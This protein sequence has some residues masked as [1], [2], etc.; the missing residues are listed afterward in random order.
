MIL[1]LNNTTTPTQPQHNLNLTQLS[2]VWHDYDFAH[3][4]KFCM[5][6]YLQKLR[7]TQQN[8]NPS[9]FWGGG[10]YPSG[11]TLPFFC[12]QNFVPVESPTMLPPTHQTTWKNLIKAFMSCIL[13]KMDCRDFSWSFHHRWKKLWDVVTKSAETLLS[14]QK[15]FGKFH[16]YFAGFEKY[17]L[18]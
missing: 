2:W 18:H 1:G 15:V 6:S 5:W 11:L 10:I 12:Y 3:P 13:I 14:W 4:L 17:P 8:L 9:I 7:I 16:A